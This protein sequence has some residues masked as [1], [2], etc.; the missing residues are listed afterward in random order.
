MEE[1]T[2]ANH[3]HRTARS[4]S[5]VANTGNG[6]CRHATALHFSVIVPCLDEAAII[7]D[8][9]AHLR[10]LEPEAEIV[11]ADGGSR[12]DTM[13]RAAAAGARVLRAPRGRGAQMNAGAAVARGAALLFL[14]A[15]CRLPPDAFTQLR[16]WL[17]GGG[18]AA[19]FR[20][21]YAQ[22]HPLLHCIGVLSR[23]ESALSSFGEGGLCLRRDA[24]TR[25]GGF[26]EWPMFEDVELLS[27]LRRRGEL[28]KLAGPVTASSRR[29]RQHGVWRQQLRNC[30]LFGL[31]RA[32]MAPDRLARHYDGR[33]ITR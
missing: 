15:D 25:T 20:I 33:A 29:Y 13:R 2:H 7:A 10:A 11:I 23:F 31:Y 8:C 4:V 28:V 14:H 1:L 21:R 3:R 6:A 22:A 24:F 16:R 27:R 26:P 5:E 12:D 18:T 19:T 32:G 17:D 9:I 30:L